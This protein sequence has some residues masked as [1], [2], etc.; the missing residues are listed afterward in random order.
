MSPGVINEPILKTLFSLKKYF[1]PKYVQ[2]ILK[3]YYAFDFEGVIQK[4]V[5]NFKRD[6]SRGGQY[7]NLCIMFFVVW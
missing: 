7:M 6:Y 5:K 3:P 2:R 4:L 1:P